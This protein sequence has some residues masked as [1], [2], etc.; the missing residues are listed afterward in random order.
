MSIWSI[1]KLLKYKQLKSAFFL[2]LRKPLFIYPTLS[3][4]VEAYRT[5]QKEFPKTHHLNGKGNAFR[6]AFWNMMLC[7]QCSNW[8]TNNDKAI[9]WAKT[10]TD[11]HEELSPNKPLDKAMDL[12]NNKIGRKLFKQLNTKSAKPNMSMLICKLPLK[13]NCLKV[14]K[15]Y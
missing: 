7:K 8:T 6:H 11:W 13:P 3:A 2:F 14:E 9:A 10:I 4:T 1:I 5:S 12:H 15:K